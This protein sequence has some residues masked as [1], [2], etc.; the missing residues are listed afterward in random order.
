MSRELKIVLIVFGLFAA[1]VIVSFVV[2]VIELPHMAKSIAQS[3]RD[4]V[5]AKKTAEKIATFTLP[6]GY[7]YDTATDMGFTQIVSVAPSDPRQRGFRIQLQGSVVP[8][9]DSSQVEG[10]KLG[11]GLVSRF[12]QCD[13][14]DDGTD[15]VTVRGV[16]VKLAVVDCPDGKIPMRIETGTFPGNAA[17][18]TITAMGIEGRDFD[19]TALHALLQSVR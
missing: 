3:G 9:N 17:H 1:L 5:A 11:M 16:V 2:L 8:S 14:K 19:T 7:A 4:P 6:P 13:L 10:M 18:A 12:A 15:D